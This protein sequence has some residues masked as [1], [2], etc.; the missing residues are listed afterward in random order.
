M[1]RIAYPSTEFP[2]LPSVAVEVPEGWEPVHVPGTTLAARLPREGAFDP[3]VVITVEQCAPDWTVER[4]LEQIRGLARSHGGD[5]SEPYAARLGES[6][7]VG[8]DAT[9]PDEDV[10]TILQAN[11]FHVVSAPAPGATSHLVQLTATVAGPSA[12]A[13][14]PLVRDVLLTTRVSPTPA[15]ADA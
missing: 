14:Y 3:N 15:G 10:D 5:V 9:W 2:G 13:D 6:D 4:S 8:C 11:L 1:T 12:E 7:Y